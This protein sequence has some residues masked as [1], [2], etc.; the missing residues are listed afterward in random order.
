LPDDD[1]QTLLVTA[2]KDA[3]FVSDLTKLYDQLV[4]VLST[5]SADVDAMR[6]Q[7]M[8][9]EP[10]LKDT[11]D[12]NGDDDQDHNKFQYCQ[13]ELELYYALWLT[14][15]YLLLSNS[16]VMGGNRASE[17]NDCLTKTVRKCEFVV[18]RLHQ[19]FEK[20]YLQL[21]FHHNNKSD[22]EWKQRILL[23][24]NEHPDLLELLSHQNS[25]FHGGDDDD[26]D[27]DDDFQENLLLNI[28]QEQLEMEEQ[29]LLLMATVPIPTSMQQ[30]D[31]K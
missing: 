15:L 13:T 22:T 2:V 14:S 21:Q 28:T 18:H 17:L 8:R 11:D 26:D 19:I 6:V 7:I 16:I 1:H 12:V 25:D 9:N 30:L 29:E 23:I 3:N 4:G 27:N 31:K 20:Q 24:T 5:P 10:S